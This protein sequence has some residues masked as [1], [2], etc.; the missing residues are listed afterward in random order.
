MIDCFYCGRSGARS[1]EHV[2]PKWLWRDLAQLGYAIAPSRGR[3]PLQGNQ[4]LLD[5]RVECNTGP[6]K[7]LDDVA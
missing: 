4:R 3:H 5:V 2:I 1:A 6:L 7:M